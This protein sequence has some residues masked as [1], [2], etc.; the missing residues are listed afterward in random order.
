MTETIDFTIFKM[1]SDLALGLTATPYTCQ[2][3]LQMTPDII[4]MVFRIFK[5]PVK[6]GKFMLKT[7]L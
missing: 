6:M 3:W 1:I 4:S 5:P 7:N 2:V